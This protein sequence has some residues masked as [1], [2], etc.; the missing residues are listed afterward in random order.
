MNFDFKKEDQILEATLGKKP[1]VAKLSQFKLFP[2]GFNMNVLMSK[3]PSGFWSILTLT[4]G[5]LAM[6]LK[7]ENAVWILPVGCFLYYSAN[8]M[9][10]FAV[11]LVALAGMYLGIPQLVYLLVFSVITMVDWNKVF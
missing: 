10:P 9:V 4:L 3:I 11:M 2:R 8:Q 6:H 7:V 5:V 1:M